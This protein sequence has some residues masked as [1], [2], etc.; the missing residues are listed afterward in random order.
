VPLKD[1]AGEFN[2]KCR[3]FTVKEQSVVF[4]LLD[5]LFKLS[6]AQKD[7]KVNSPEKVLERYKQAMATARSLIA[8]PTGICLD[9]E[10]TLEF[11]GGGDYTSDLP[12]YIMRYV[13]D[14][15]NEAVRNA[16][17]FRKKQ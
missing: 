12:F 4:G 11:W 15:Q 16:M 9:S 5:E 8:Y 1:E 7:P 14:H 10:L 3:A 6:A 2:V 13:L 17:L